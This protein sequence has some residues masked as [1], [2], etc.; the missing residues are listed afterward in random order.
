ML[1]A[2]LQD[3]IGVDHE[4][5]EHARCFNL[6][7]L[8]V[9]IL[10]TWPS[11]AMERLATLKVLIDEWAPMYVRLHPAKYVKPKFHA[12]VIHVVSALKPY[13]KFASRVSAGG[14]AKVP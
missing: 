5:A 2:F 9:G 8:I 10:A 12:F 3:T 7:R 11:K 1:D 6:L 14:D 4:L 13:I